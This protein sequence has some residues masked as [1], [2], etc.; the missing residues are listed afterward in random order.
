MSVCLAIAFGFPLIQRVSISDASIQS[1]D[2][3][4][5]LFLRRL[6]LTHVD[7]IVHRCMWRSYRSSQPT[8]SFLLPYSSI[9]AATI[10]NYHDIKKL[11]FASQI[12]VN[13]GFTGTLL[14]TIS[15]LWVVPGVY[16]VSS[17][18]LTNDWSL[19]SSLKWKSQGATSRQ[20]NAQRQIST[21]N[22]P[23]CSFRAFVKREGPDMSTSLRRNRALRLQDCFSKRTGDRIRQFAKPRESLDDARGSCF[24]VLKPQDHY[25]ATYRVGQ[26]WVL[27][28]ERTPI[29]VKSDRVWSVERCER[30][31]GFR[32]ATGAIA[33]LKFTLLRVFRTRK[34]ECGR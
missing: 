2:L 28:F 23:K 6:L 19:V 22:K 17:Q 13:L 16:V 15:E 10:G 26:Q 27:V 4:L 8:R 9:M 18:F 31:V 20:R 34:Y 29:D 25:L 12:L 5:Q 32:T 21:L 14:G 3:S 30:S 7:A 11:L 1:C 33:N 24:G